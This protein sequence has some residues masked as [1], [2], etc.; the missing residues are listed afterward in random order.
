MKGP[1]NWARARITKVKEGDTPENSSHRITIA[2]DTSVFP[3][4]EGTDYLA[5]TLAN[6][7]AG[8]T[9][10][11][12]F[13]SYQMNWF[14]ESIWVSKWL[15]EVFDEKACELLGIYEEDLKARKR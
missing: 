3:D 5:P 10:A 4:R 15:E 7:N 12:A 11:L 14:T 13:Q 2:I 8:V 1:L 9:F 6:V